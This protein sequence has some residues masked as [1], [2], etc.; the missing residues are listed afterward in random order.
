MNGTR[1]S[2]TFEGRWVKTIV[3][4]RPIRAAIRAAARAEMPASMLAAKRAAPM[5]PGSAP[6]RRWNQ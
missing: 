2:S 3:R 5:T 6:K 1:I 4:I